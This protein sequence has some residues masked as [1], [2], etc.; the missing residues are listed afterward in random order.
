MKGRE[1]QILP[2]I[3][4]QLQSVEYH[5]DILVYCCKHT[6]QLQYEMTKHL[7]NHGLNKKYIPQIPQP[8]N[9]RET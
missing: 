4:D 9:S 1:I 7:H 6:R 2:A 8:Q 3:N 5:R